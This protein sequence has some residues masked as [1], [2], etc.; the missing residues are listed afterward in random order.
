VIRDLSM[1][2]LYQ[3]PSV[4]HPG[5]PPFQN[6]CWA[7]IGGSVINFFHKTCPTKWS[8][9]DVASAY[10]SVPS[11]KHSALDQTANILEVFEFFKIAHRSLGDDLKDAKTANAIMQSIDSGRPVLLALEQ[12]AKAVKAVKAP[13]APKAPKKEAKE[14]K[15]SKKQTKPTKAKASADPSILH[16][17][18]L[19]A[20]K[21][22][23]DGVL[24]QFGIK[25]TSGANVNGA[26]VPDS[27]VWKPPF[28]KYESY[29]VIDC[30]E[31]HSTSGGM[32]L[33]LP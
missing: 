8:V 31:V 11:H 9:L 27:L 24:K 20:Y 6:L 1:T 26:D 29:S 14:R 16:Y 13:K 2:V 10:L 5:T 12:K 22:S 7:A 17:I 19:V 33:P 3:D 4:D 28:V 32:C 25:D 23:P 30:V 15:G 18:M 21:T